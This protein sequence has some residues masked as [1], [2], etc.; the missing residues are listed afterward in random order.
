M[1]YRVN[2]DP[3]LFDVSPELITAENLSKFIN[4]ERFPLIAPIG[5]ENYIDYVERGIP[6]VWIGVPNLIEAESFRDI[7]LPFARKFKGELSFTWVDDSQFHE[8]VEELGMSHLLPSQRL[9]V[10][11]VELSTCH[12]PFGSGKDRTA[13]SRRRLVTPFN[14]QCIIVRPHIHHHLLFTVIQDSNQFQGSLSPQETNQ[15]NTN[16]VLTTTI[17]M[18]KI[19]KHFST[20][21]K[22]ALFRYS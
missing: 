22:K 19:Y 16:I 14:C 6:I 7:L 21:L 8:H 1:I 17:L 13:C 3:I 20:T 4:D 5:P 15:E 12:L 18:Q 9:L 10:W 11:C 2:E